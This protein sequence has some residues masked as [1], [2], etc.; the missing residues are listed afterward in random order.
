MSCSWKTETLSEESEIHKLLTSL[1]GQRWL[2]RGQ[3]ELHENLRP[4]SE[5]NKKNGCSRLKKLMTERQAIDLFR[6]SVKYFAS[7][8]EQLAMSDDVVALMVLRHYGVPT[9][10]LDWSN[11]PYVATFFA[12]ENHD[13]KHAELWAFDHDTYAEEGKKQWERWP[14]CLDEKG[15]F[16][17]R[18]TAFT[19]DDPPDWFV[20]YFYPSGF[21]RQNAQQGLYS[22]TANFD[23]DHALYINNLLKSDATHKRWII[24][25]DLK[26]PLRNW[27]HANHGIWRGAL[28][29]D[30]A[31]A[32]DTAASVY[33]RCV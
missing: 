4:K 33:S 6:S 21:P 7:D 2:C 23:R 11:S 9:R 12:V 24:D 31:G 18:F 22:L 5:R 15:Q 19:V 27:L 29:P 3:S 26:K 28:Y 20:C 10:L 16:Q 32:A 14:Q 1:K 25:K 8:G 17:A 13:D 30:T